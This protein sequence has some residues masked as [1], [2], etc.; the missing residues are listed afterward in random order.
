M[1]YMH[2]RRAEEA[3]RTS[4]MNNTVTAVLEFLKTMK[5]FAHRLGL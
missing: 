5:I 3:T 2:A 4:V 1:M